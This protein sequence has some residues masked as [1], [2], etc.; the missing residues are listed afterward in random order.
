MVR[1]LFL[2]HRILY[3]I[4]C[5]S[6]FLSGCGSYHYFGETPVV[7]GK[8]PKFTSRDTL[9][10]KL[11]EDRAGYDVTSYDLDLKLNPGDKSIGGKVIMRFK[12]VLPL[13]ILR[14]D[15]YPNLKI[16][17]VSS[18]AGDMKFTRKDRAVYVS[19][20]APLVPDKFYSL[21]ISYYGNPQIA[22]NPPSEGGSVWKTDKYGNP[23]AGVSC[24]TD[25]ASIWFPCKEHLSDEPDSVRLRMSVPRGLTVVSNGLMTD[26]TTTDSADIY[27]WATHYPV[28]PYDITYYAGKF[29]CFSD[30]VITKY[31]T[32][33]TDYWVLPEDLEKAEKHF[34]QTKDI[35]RFYSEMYGPYPWMN[36]DFKLVEA[37]YEGMEHQTAIAYG[38]GFKDNKYLGGDYIII[39]ETAHEWWGNAVTVSDFSDIWLQEGFATYSEMLWIEHKLGTDKALFAKKYLYGS[40]VLNKRPVVG[41]PDV[42]YWLYKDGDVYMKGALILSTIRNLVKNDSLFFGILRTFYSEHSKGTHVTT[43]DFQEIVERKTGKNWDTFF[44]VYLYNRLVPV[45]QY[46]YGTYKGLSDPS[47]KLWSGVPF[48]VCKWTRVPTG[49]SMPVEFRCKETN[50]TYSI[51]ATESPQFFYLEDMDPLNT[52]KCNPDL[53]YF[54]SSF[55]VGIMADVLKTLG[56]SLKDINSGWDKLDER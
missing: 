50:V 35:L 6:V 47:K 25:G 42:N 3:L 10:G 1:S 21:S 11:G 15:L 49:F 36:E 7:G 52:L 39:H 22:R 44:K 34:I 5:S 28:N 33:K 19:L 26:H 24:E 43:S 16:V 40:I 9:I 13:K 46:Y 8:Y 31:G 45:L 32:I 41:P 51:N 48:V 20:P 38:N 55:I 27:T 53:S 4:F 29:E 56:I 2:K 17:S 54:E 14:F 12:A 37:P 23:W 30:T 18:E